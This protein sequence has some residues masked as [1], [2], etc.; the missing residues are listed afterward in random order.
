MNSRRGKRRS[1]RI[2]RQQNKQR[3]ALAQIYRE[4][5]APRANRPEWR[6]GDAHESV[7]LK[8]DA[9]HTLAVAHHAVVVDVD[10]QLVVQRS[11]G[12]I[13]PPDGIDRR[14]NDRHGDQGYHESD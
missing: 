8:I 9:D 10:R 11:G 12:E 5:L 14:P 1:R 4:R 6:V 3:P 13:P 2:V 7:R